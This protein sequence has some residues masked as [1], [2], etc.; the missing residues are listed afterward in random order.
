[1]AAIG[2]A[3]KRANGL[4]DAPPKIAAPEPEAATPAIKRSES[5][6]NARPISNPVSAKMIAR[7]PSNPRSPTMEWASKRLAAKFIEKE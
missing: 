5:P 1:M 2:A 6:G 4:R 7:I 3:I